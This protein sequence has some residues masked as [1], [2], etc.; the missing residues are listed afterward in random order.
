MSRS[1]HRFTH[2]KTL[3]LPKAV[4]AMSASSTAHVLAPPAELLASS[5]AGIYVA[6]PRW[7]A[8]AAQQSV[9]DSWS[10]PLWMHRHL[11]GSRRRSRS[12]AADTLVYVGLWVD[13]PPTRALTD[14]ANRHS[15]AWLAN[16]SAVLPLDDGTELDLRP[17]LREGRVWSTAFGPERCA[18]L[19]GTPLAAS[20][21][22]YFDR[23]FGACDEARG[24]MAPAHAAMA[25]AAGVAAAAARATRGARPAAQHELFFY[26]HIP[27]PYIEWP[28][29]SVRYRLWREYHGTPGALFEGFD[30]RNTVT[31]YAVASA[32][33]ACAACSYGC[34]R[35]YVDPRAGGYEDAPM[36]NASDYY[37]AMAASEVCVVPRG[38]DPQTP[39]LP[40]AV[41]AGC[42]PAI[43]VDGALPFEEVFDYGAGAL[44]LTPEAVLARPGALRDAVRALTPERR[45]A[46]RAHLR[47]HAALFEYG[48]GDGRGAEAAVAEAM[49]TKHAARLRLVEQRRAVRAEGDDDDDAR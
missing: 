12:I 28:V 45:E 25:A 1:P 33:E 34:K 18:S 16:G 19:H 31:P 37:A 5:A 15:A 46:M 9:S 29:S 27:K 48:R 22:V 32:A 26:G 8:E 38:D 49:L 43:V 13:R 21:L 14:E 30:V 10:V 4:F 23:A 7:H 36:L 3:T 41:L 35:C 17:L 39:K 42:I 20:S 44:R 40:E 6:T 47:R 2:D 24:V 11:L